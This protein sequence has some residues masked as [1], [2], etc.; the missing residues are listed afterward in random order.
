MELKAPPDGGMEAEV[1]LGATV[2]D[3]VGV[4]EATG[5]AVGATGVAVGGSGVIVGA[6]V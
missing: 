3:H 5:V 6:A 4:A 2:G 1:G